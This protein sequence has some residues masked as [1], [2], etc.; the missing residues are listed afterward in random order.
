MCHGGLMLSTDKLAD[1]QLKSGSRAAEG[2][3]TPSRRSPVL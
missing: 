3:V 2:A 1:A